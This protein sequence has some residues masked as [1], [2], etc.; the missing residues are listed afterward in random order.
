MSKFLKFIVGILLAAFIVSGAALLIPSYIGYNTTIVDSATT[1][2]QRMGTVIYTKQEPVSELANG[3]KILELR[4]DA[5]NVRT[6]K[7]YDRD[8]ETIAYEDGTEGTLQVSGDYYLVKAAVPALGYLSIAMQSRNGLIFLGLI[9]L[10][11]IVLFILSEV[12]RHHAEVMGDYDTY[13]EEDDDEYFENLAATH[14]LNLEKS[15]AA[16]EVNS[17]SE[18]DKEK[19]DRKSGKDKKEKRTENKERRSKRDR[20]RGGDRQDEGYESEGTDGPAEDYFEG[21]SPEGIEEDLET[22]L[23]SMIEAGNAK[24]QQP[25]VRSEGSAAEEPEKEETATAEQFPLEEDTP[26]EKGDRDEVQI[27]M[28]AKTAEELLQKAYQDGLDPKVHEDEIT[29]VTLI[30]YSDSL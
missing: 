15:K 25:D 1:G 10:L 22:Q 13:D 5:V 3:D 28:P 26:S 27:A 18:E 19:K 4:G 6:V 29:G 17:S 7:S 12:M 23:R 2:N 11:I 9:L 14:Q 8:A 16:A 30:D 24:A 21:K 20:R